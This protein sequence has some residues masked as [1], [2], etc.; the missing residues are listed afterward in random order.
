MIILL[1]QKLIMAS[2]S[3]YMIYAQYQTLML[4]QLRLH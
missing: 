2:F 3:Y 1:M 4:T